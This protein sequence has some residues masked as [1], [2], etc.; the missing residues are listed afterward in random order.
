MPFRGFMVSDK[1]K[2]NVIRH[3]VGHW[4][5]AKSLGFDAGEISFYFKKMEQYE[6]HQAHAHINIHP[7]LSSIED[8]D[9]YLIRRVSI[10]WAGVM[11]Q[12][13]SDKRPVEKILETDGVS[14]HDKLG[15]LCRI[16]RGIR[17]PNDTEAEFEQEQMNK[18][19]DEA[20]GKAKHIHNSNEDEI[21]Y[22]VKII[23]SEVKEWNRKYVFS[24]DLIHQ[25]LSEK[26]VVEA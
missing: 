15:E 19:R 24:V 7:S 26:S 14:D 3:E 12:S 13:V 16:I 9:D 4:Y 17:F 20:W 6:S 25:W 18:I 22:L 5:L 11:F 21:E 2:E 1:Y 8:I 23:C 10:L